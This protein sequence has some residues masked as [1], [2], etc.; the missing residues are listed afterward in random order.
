[1]KKYFFIGALSLAW[2]IPAAQPQKT[3]TITTSAQ[4]Q[5][6]IRYFKEQLVKR[7]KNAFHRVSK[8]EFEN[9]IERLYNDAPA[10]KDYQVIVRLLQITAKVGDGHTVVHIPASFKRYPIALN[11]FGDSLYVNAATAAYKEVLGARLI[12]IGDFTLEEVN[13]R[14]A[15]VLSQAENKWYDMNMGPALMLIPEV[16]VTLGI[17]P[18]YNHAS[19]RFLD[20]GNKEIKLEIAPAATGPGNVFMSASKSQPLFR[21]KQTDPFWFSY[22]EE[23]NAVYLRTPVNFLILLRKRRRHG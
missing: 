22:I 20:A 19:F 8:E 16:L 11:W 18:D 14:L 2:L 23:I 1:M 9:D 21:Q 13:K 12:G 15:S 5:E 7:H 10:L 3:N 6:D 17:V 4:W